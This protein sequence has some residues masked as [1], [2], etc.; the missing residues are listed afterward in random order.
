LK[1]RKPA[2]AVYSVK[3]KDKVV[4][5][6]IDDGIDA[7]R[8]VLRYLEEND[9][10]IT[11]F[12]TTGTVTDWQ[13]WRD[14][15]PVA[16]IQNHTVMHPTLPQR[17]ATGAEQEICGANEAIVE[18]TEQVPWMVRPPYGAYDPSTL[19]AAGE[20]GLDY[21]V[22]WSVSAPG[23]S[24]QYQAVGTKLKPGDIVLTHFRKDLAKDL[25]KIVEEITA[26]GFEVG[27]LEDYLTPRGWPVTELPEEATM[28]TSTESR[29]YPVSN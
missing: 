18:N 22:H 5:I 13:Y 8:K 21:L 14:I 15:A 28:A 9:I 16:S 17:G 19:A 23:D 7:D 25:P 20:C 24:L 3:T 2:E 11:V 6:T 26:Q 27:R 4:F 10:P 29:A 1:S 12:L